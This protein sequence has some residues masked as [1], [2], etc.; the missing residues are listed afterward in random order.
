[1]FNKQLSQQ[2]EYFFSGDTQLSSILSWIKSNEEILKQYGL[3]ARKKKKLPKECVELLRQAHFFDLARGVESGGLGLTSSAQARVLESL[4]SID[5]SISWCVM[6]G[7]DSGI[8]RGFLSESVSKHFFPHPGIISA[9]WIHPQGTATA[10]G[11]GTCRIH[12]QWQFASG[13]DHADVV[14]AGVKFYEAKKSEQWTWRIV[15]LDKSKVKIHNTWDT[16]GLHGSGSQHYEVEELIIPVEH[17]FSLHSPYLTGPLFQPHDAI[18]RKMA[19]IPLGVAVGTVKN[20]IQILKNNI[21][22]NK[23]LGNKPNERV[24]NSVGR[25]TAD[26]LAQRA[27]VYSSLNLAWDIYTYSDLPSDH[28]IALVTSAAAR[29]RAF[30]LSRQITLQAGDLLGAQ[31]V[32]K[33]KGDLGSK[34]SD[35]NVMAQHAV[36][37]DSILELVG[38]RIMGGDAAGPFL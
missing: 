6:I 7:M 17:T 35:L 20:L 24:L 32:Y 21:L 2:D 26:L 10:L 18:L 36:G 19:G 27:S 14:L 34:L 16:W 15:A 1:M 8:Y 11:D 25:I 29:Q 38:N 9:G 5:A 30:S 33:S 28:T 3:E 12:G 13:I 4:A 23:D 31:A 22:K 37:Q